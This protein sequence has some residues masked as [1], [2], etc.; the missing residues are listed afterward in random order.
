MLAWDEN[1]YANVIGYAVTIDDARTDLGM[2][3]AAPDGSCGCQLSFAA[4]IADRHTVIVSAY[5]ADGETA[6]LPFIVGPTA[7]AGGPYSAQ[8][9]VPLVATGAG[10]TDQTASIATYSWNWG[11]GSEVTTATS[12]TASHAY[13]YAGTFSITLT[14]SDVNGATSSATTTATIAFGQ[15]PSTPTN[16]APADGATN[17]STSATLTWSA[18]GATSYTVNFGT[19]NPPPPVA[20][21]LTV[22]S[23]QPG[24]LNA[25]TSYYWQ[26]IAVNSA[27]TTAGPVWTF[28]T[29][30][31]GSDLPPPWANEDIGTVGLSGSA[32]YADPTFTV[33]GAGSNIRG[34]A[35]AFQFVY[36]ALA[37]DGSIV[38]RVTS[39]VNTASFAK[40]GIMFR[41][42]LGAGAADVILDVRPG[43]WVELLARS[44]TNG[45]TTYLGGAGASFPVWLQL[46]RTGASIAASMSGD[47]VS[48]TAVGS[49]AIGLPA[50]SEVGLAVTSHTTS[51]LNLA[52]F[53]SVTVTSSSTSG[54]L[55]GQ[56]V[57]DVGVTGSTTLNAGVY[58]VAGSGAN[59][60]GSADAFQFA[61]QPLTGDGAIVARVTS[62]MNTDSNAQ[63]GIMFRESLAAGAAD[64]ILDISP[65]G[66]VEF[67]SRSATNGSTA[68]L[69]GV[70]ASFPVW[71]QLARTGATIAAS[72]SADGVSWTA[73]GSVAIALPATCDV[74]L[75]VTSHT[76]SAL[77]AATFDSVTVTSSTSGALNGQD[78]GAVGMMG[79][80]TLTAGAY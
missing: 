17:A 74:G 40:A 33:E 4:Y 80:T 9:G 23:Y 13:G 15:P 3:P 77:N 65:D 39:E 30:S 63:A 26:I 50:T 45:S 68:Y 75:A 71:L 78:V 44:A 69:G 56:D 67:I 43:G 36:Q 6:T 22:A 21:N 35:D 5:N 14:V 11:D 7:N 64:V 57:G 73:V 29:S 27:G 1:P 10:S 19:E 24:W 38:A 61:Y 37:G 58:T 55:T 42:S 12:A 8:P 79:S 31:T 49:V 76:T 34:H 52:T 25:N 46:V 59:I 51:A 32:S 48:W 18:T 66:W 41:E 54:T 20:A 53:D 47:G 60:W 62:E 16:P 2:S 72:A 70:G 28:S